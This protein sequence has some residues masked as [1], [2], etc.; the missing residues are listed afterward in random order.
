MILTHWPQGKEW[1]REEMDA[2]ARSIQSL[3]A[4]IATS[5]VVRAALEVKYRPSIAEFFECY[6]AERRRLQPEVAPL[7]AA[8]Q[9][10]P[11]WVKRWMCAR[12]LADRWGKETDRRRFSEQGHFGDLTR[13]LMPEGA[14]V[15]EAN[16][17]P[18]EE[19]HKAFSGAFRP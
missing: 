15:E 7:E 11:F 10:I 5:T 3:N 19:F 4:E 8:P 12:L 17:I 1:G 14:W 18:D 9:V 13:E 2:Y 6:K 16:S